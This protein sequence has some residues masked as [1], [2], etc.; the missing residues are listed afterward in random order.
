[1]YLLLFILKRLYISIP[2]HSKF[3]YIHLK[4]KNHRITISKTLQFCYVPL[5][6]ERTQL[7]F[8][9]ISFSGCRLPIQEMRI[10]LILGE[11]KKIFP[12]RKRIRN[13]VGQRLGEHLRASQADLCDLASAAEDCSRVQAKQLNI[14]EPY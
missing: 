11:D 9:G 13:Y 8:F 10:V 7:C 14:M 6:S 12:H 1:M 2:M 4:I 3:I 5:H